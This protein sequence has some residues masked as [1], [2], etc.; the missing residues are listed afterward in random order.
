MKH[1]TKFNEE[2]HVGPPEPINHDFDNS[3][4]LYLFEQI[5][6]I[7]IEFETDEILHNCEVGTIETSKSFNF[8]FSRRLDFKSCDIRKKVKDGN[9]FFKYGVTYTDIKLDEGEKIYFKLYFKIPIEKNKLI[10]LSTLDEMEIL[11]TA[12][13]LQNTYEIYLNFDW[14]HD[15]YKP[16]TIVFVEK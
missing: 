2:F 1:L 9:T 14:K 12:K 10:K 4:T 13:R 5:R 3:K 16:L 6:D 15:E 8:L 11:Q 7:F